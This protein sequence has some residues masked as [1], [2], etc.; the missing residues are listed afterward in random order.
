MK[1]LRQLSSTED[2]LSYKEKTADLLN[3]LDQEE[4]SFRLQPQNRIRIACWLYVFKN[5]SINIT[6]SCIITRM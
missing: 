2:Q 4:H 1:V 5:F 6:A 3:R